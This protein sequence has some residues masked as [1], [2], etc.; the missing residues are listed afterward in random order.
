MTHKFIPLTTVLATTLTLVACSSGDD[1]G[2]YSSPT[3]IED[4]LQ[5]TD[6]ECKTWTQWDDDSGSC[7]MGTRGLQHIDTE[8]SNPAL[9]AAVTFDDP[10]SNESISPTRQ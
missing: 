7:D 9:H 5:G 1:S 10:I 6:Y 8:V 2:N 4:K 3:E